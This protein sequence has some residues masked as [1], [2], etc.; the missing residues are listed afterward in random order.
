V[1][2]V[3]ISSQE[4]KPEEVMLNATDVARE[5]IASRQAEAHE[6]A[7]SKTVRLARRRKRL[8]DRI[9]RVDEQLAGR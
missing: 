5:V 7:R 8:N 2:Y 4:P 6:A 1:S 3:T 9:Q